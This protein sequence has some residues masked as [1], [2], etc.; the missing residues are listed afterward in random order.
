MSVSWLE[1]MS[2]WAAKVL[3]SLEP[4]DSIMRFQKLWAWK[5]RPRDL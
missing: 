2:A 5:L 4:A 1:V 3:H